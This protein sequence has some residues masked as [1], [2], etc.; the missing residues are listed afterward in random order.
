MTVCALMQISNAQGECKMDGEYKDKWIE[1]QSWDWEVE[2]ETSWTKGGGASVGKP[3]PGKLNWEHY[4]DR[5]SCTLLKYICQGAAFEEVKLRMFKGTGGEN[6]KNNVFYEMV[7]KGAFLTKVAS[8]A[9]EEGNISQKV[10]MVFKEV[11]ISYSMQ[12][13]KGKRAG[14]LTPAGNYAWDIPAG[15]AN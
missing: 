9:T 2:A 12:E 15:R 5:S 7:M 14:S 6:L 13:D 3:N 1:V 4:F 10:E 8:A 11:A